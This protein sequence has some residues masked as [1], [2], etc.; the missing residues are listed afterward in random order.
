MGHW[1]GP[2][3][4]RLAGLS[5]RHTPDK[6]RL[7]TKGHANDPI[8]VKNGVIHDGMA[9]T[10]LAKRNGKTHLQAYVWVN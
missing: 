3:S 8:Y 1:A 4:V 2:R 7:P 5:Y 9:R 6:G 10:E